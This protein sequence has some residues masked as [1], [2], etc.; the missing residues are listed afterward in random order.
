MES[1]IF[2]K[3]SSSKYAMVLITINWGVLWLVPILMGELTN[4]GS[5]VFLSCVHSTVSYLFIYLFF[6]FHLFIFFFFS[7]AERLFLGYC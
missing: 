1:Y 6:F 4:I 5:S 7:W 2:A 3:I